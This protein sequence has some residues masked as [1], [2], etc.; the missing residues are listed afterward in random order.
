MTLFDNFERRY[1]IA[2]ILVTTSLLQGGYGRNKELSKERKKMK[3]AGIGYMKSYMETRRGSS[4]NELPSDK[5][6]LDMFINVN[7]LSPEE[8]ERLLML[9]DPCPFKC[10]M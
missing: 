4:C 10:Q 8:K 3:E 6:I 2:V 5:Q 9:P 7:K 1:A